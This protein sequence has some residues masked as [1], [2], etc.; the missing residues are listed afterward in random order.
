M[1]AQLSAQIKML[2]IELLTAVHF[3]PT[4]KGT[5]NVY[6]NWAEF[7]GVL[8]RRLQS[9]SVYWEKW[10]SSEILITLLS[11]PLGQFPL[12]HLSS[13]HVNPKLRQG[14]DTLKFQINATSLRRHKETEQRET[15]CV[16]SHF[17]NYEDQNKFVG[18]RNSQ[19]SDLHLM[20]V[21]ET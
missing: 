9:M 17:P 6:L 18:A 16:F 2:I 11:A 20:K 21:I 7:E 14:R 10:L 1:K 12:I 4:E 13:V 3:L 19:I 8:A 15:F 5:K